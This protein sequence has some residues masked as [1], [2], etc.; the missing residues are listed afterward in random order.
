MRKTN[1]WDGPSG[2]TFDTKNFMRGWLVHALSLLMRLRVIDCK[3][4]HKRTDE[5]LREC[6][7]ADGMTAF[8][9]S[10]AFFGACLL[11]LLNA[12]P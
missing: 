1:T 6:C 7:S 10:Y 9:A 11:G 5:N 12:K 8:R 2:P 4:Y 3:V